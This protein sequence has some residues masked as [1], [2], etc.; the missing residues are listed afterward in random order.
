MPRSEWPKHQHPLAPERVWDLLDAIE[1]TLDKIR[2]EY[3]DAF[4]Y[5][6]GRRDRPTD[7]NYSKDG[8]IKV[9]GAKD[10]TGDTATSQIGRRKGLARRCNDLERMRDKA[11]GILNTLREVQTEDEGYEPLAPFEEVDSAIKKES[12]M[13]RDKRELLELKRHHE[14]RLAEIANKL[15]MVS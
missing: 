4:A 13:V 10:P 2:A 5:V 15:R 11:L 7:E 12:E 9:P 1:I 14:L 8:P 3:P 6:H